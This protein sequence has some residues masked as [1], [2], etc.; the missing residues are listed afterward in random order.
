VEPGAARRTV[1]VL[2][3]S[4]RDRGFWLLAGV[5]A[6]CG[7]STNG[8]LWTHFVPAARDHGMAVTVAAALVSTIGVFSLV[9]TVA[10]GWLTDRFDP[11]ALL[12]AYFGGRAVLLAVLPLLFGPQAGPAMVAFV[13]VFGLVDVATVPPVILLCRRM[14]GGDGAIVFGWVGAAHQVGAGAM[15]VVGGLVRDVTGGYGP[16]WALAA[17]LCGLA[18]VL[19]LRAPGAEEAESAAEESGSVETPGS[20]GESDTGGASGSAGEEP[21]STVETDAD[22]EAG[23]V[24]V[25]A[26]GASGSARERVVVEP[27]DAGGRSGS[28]G[29]RAAAGSPGAGGESGSAGAAGAGGRQ[30]GARR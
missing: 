2:V 11:R 17:V 12:V 7:A 18:V 27:S 23:S 25:D 20:D 6:I 28:V 13:V 21:V 22:G 9:G 19:A 14:F 15:A 5:F 30:T 10:S 1:R 4:V 16:V 3:R 26:G 24:E 29:E 8:I